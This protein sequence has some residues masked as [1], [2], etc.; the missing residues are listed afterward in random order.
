MNKN[1]KKALT[2][3]L[4]I[5][6]YNESVHL[7]GC[8]DAVA[9]QTVPP[10]EVIVVDNNSTDD[11]AKIAKSYRFVRLI[12]EKEQ[13]LT[14]ARN[15][16]FDA[17]KG[18]IIGRIDADSVISP[19]WTSRVKQD[20]SD[21]AVAGVTGL[22]QTRVLL[23]VRNWYSTFWSRVYFWAVHAYFDIMT[24]WGANM[25]IRRSM[26]QE[27]KDS[28]AKSDNDAH[29][30]QDLSFVIIGHGGRI[31]QDNKLLIKTSGG[32]YLYWPKFWSYFMK[33]FRTKSRH[34]KLGTLR[35]AQELKIGFWS[36]LPGALAAWVLTVVFIIYSLL[37]WP[38]FAFIL[39][40]GKEAK[41]RMR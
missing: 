24:M 40:S 1:H 30:D 28:T 27:V 19:D 29:E 21:P 31:I 18:D 15:A 16:G 6:A 20:F 4:V 8:L 10:D 35:G 7:R 34:Q 26:W 22:G 25:A 3:S 17:A 5:P 12:S 23:G 36:S 32:G 33:F 41:E 37:S 9:S 11:T 38:I 39:R 14:Q 2:L 13:G